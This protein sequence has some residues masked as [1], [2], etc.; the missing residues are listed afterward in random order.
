MLNLTVF[1]SIRRLY[2]KKQNKNRVLAVTDAV[3]C[4]TQCQQ[5]LIGQLDLTVA[6][7]NNHSVNVS[8]LQSCTLYNI[9][10]HCTELHWT[11]KG[12]S[13][14]FNGHRHIYQLVPGYTMH[15]TA[16]HCNCNVLH[17]TVLHCTAMH[18]SGATDS[19]CGAHT[20][21]SPDTYLVS[22]EITP[23]TKVIYKNY[24]GHTFLADPG[25]ARGCSTNSHT[26]P[27]M[28]IKRC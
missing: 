6:A 3:V 4:T 18:C 5:K 24:S 12:F 17:F 22:H 25:K 2:P 28:A 10:L 23:R 8:T 21:G 7:L 19:M 1:L 13:G 11:L 26:F 14:E 9:K 16:L 20:L 27:L 15:L